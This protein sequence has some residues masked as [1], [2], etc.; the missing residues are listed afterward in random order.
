[1]KTTAMCFCVAVNLFFDRSFSTI[2]EK[3]PSLFSLI[4]SLEKSLKNLEK[5]EE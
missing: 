3:L 2:G 5:R 4:S 1:M